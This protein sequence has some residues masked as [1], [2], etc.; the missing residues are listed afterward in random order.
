MKS[1]SM[2]GLGSWPTGIPEISTVLKYIVDVQKLFVEL[3][4][5]IKKWMKR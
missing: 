3:M 1:G 5:E 2:L 4:N